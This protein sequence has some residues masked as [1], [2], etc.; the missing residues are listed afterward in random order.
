MAFLGELRAG[1]GLKL[2]CN[3]RVTGGYRV[4]GANCV[5]LPENQLAYG[6]V[7]R[8][9]D[10]LKSIDNNDSLVLHGAYAGL[11]FAW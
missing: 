8:R 2:G 7:T 11:E 5:A 1:V 6:R 3:W 10:H 4:V 9:L